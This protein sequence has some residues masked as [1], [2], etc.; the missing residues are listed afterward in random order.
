MVKL[1]LDNFGGDRRGK[2]P[3]P[4]HDIECFHVNARFSNDL[5]NI[6]SFSIQKIL[7]LIKFGAEAV[8]CR[9]RYGADVFYYVPAPPKRVAFYRDCFVLFVVSSIFS[10]L[11]LPLARERA[12]GMAATRCLLMGAMDR[13]I[14][15]LLP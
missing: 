15:A 9:F 2:A 13:P 12:G 3:A 8:W 6:G 5:A 1:M 4:T 10:A 7:R 14:F 11:Y